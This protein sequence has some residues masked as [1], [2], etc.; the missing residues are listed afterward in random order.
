[1][2]DTIDQGQFWSTWNSLNNT[3]PQEL[4]IQ[5]G[6]I[7]KDHFKKLYTHQTDPLNN[8]NQLKVIEKLNALESCIK[9]NQN[10]LDYPITLEELN[11]KTEIPQM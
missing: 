8:P 7:W 6:Q 3:K 1:M 11:G 10:P 4:A 9:N 5:D 2:E